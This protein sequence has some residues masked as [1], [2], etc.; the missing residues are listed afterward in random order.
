LER[1]VI[2]GP[3]LASYSLTATPGTFSGSTRLTYAYQWKRCDARGRRCKNVARA[4]SR[5]YHL[6]APDV[7]HRLTVGVT[8]TD[9]DH[10]RAGQTAVRTGAILPKKHLQLRLAA[11]GRVRHAPLHAHARR[12]VPLAVTVTAPPTLPVDHI[13][14]CIRL[15]AALRYVSSSPAA[16]RTGH[17]FCWLLPSLVARRSS[18]FTLLVKAR[19]R[20]AMTA[21]ATATARH[22]D[23]A[24][25]V[26]AMLARG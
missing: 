1:P 13:R 21:E 15:S 16:Q 20:G 4:M 22:S 14:V 26:V 9:P 24:G 10:R 18:R 25:A 8:A 6:T 12:P 11:A 3:Q 17:R 7:G 19:G 23:R 2:H 5:I